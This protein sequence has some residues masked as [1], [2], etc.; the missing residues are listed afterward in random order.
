MCIL[1][2]VVLNLLMFG[3]SVLSVFAIPIWYM[4]DKL[5]LQKFVYKMQGFDGLNNFTTYVIIAEIV[6]ILWTG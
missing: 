1:P 6:I 4:F 3:L 5:E 2:A